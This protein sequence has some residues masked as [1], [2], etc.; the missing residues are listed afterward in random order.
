[1]EKYDIVIIGAGI[2]GLSLAHFCARSGMKTLVLEKTDRPGGCFHSHE[3]TGD[4][5]GFWLELG[6]HTCY[7]SYGNL[8]A[9]MEER[10][11]LGELVKREKVGFNLLV[12]GQLKS[13]PSQLDFLELFASLPHMLGANKEG[14]TM[15]SYY[16][17][18]LGPKNY[19]RVLGPVFNAI[20]SQTADD[21]PADA[22]FKKRPK[23][24]DVRKDFTFT[25]GLGTI[26]DAIA[27]D[28]AIE[29]LTGR[30]VG[31]VQY[32]GGVFTTVSG[33]DVYESGSLALA[34][35]P[36]AAARILKASFPELSGQ[37]SMIKMG[38]VETVGVALPK[39]AV[40]IKPLAGII[41][42]GGPFYS[43]VSRDTV[44]HDSLRGFAFHFRPGLLGYDEKLLRI[45]ETLKVPAL[46]FS[47]TAL[48]NDNL[49]PSLTVG[50]GKW[51]SK[52][53]AL[54]AGGRLALTGNYFSGVAIEDCV[55]RSRGEFLRLRGAGG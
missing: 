10:G 17:K 23:R 51:L 15:R 7:S 28:P 43:A 49:V 32:D 33:E 9:L 34:C 6:A 19:E 45:A 14:A 3:F 5:A 16:S 55:A 27:S 53:D 41:A 44:K 12:D 8:I 11:M 26:T 40:A 38:G 21:F 54:L 20:I 29:F 39:E 50:H 2:S 30:E 35:P 18:I 31:E 47:G 22:L 13:I 24:K 48:K 25:R 36:P 4:A 42:A 1:M 46:E 52:T 37:L